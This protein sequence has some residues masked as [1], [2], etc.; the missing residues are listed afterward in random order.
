MAVA[1]VAILALAM[2]SDSTRVA[3]VSVKKVALATQTGV[4]KSKLD[5]EEGEASAEAVEEEFV[6]NLDKIHFPN[7]WASFQKTFG[8]H[9]TWAITILVLAALTWVYVRFIRP[10]SWFK[11]LLK[12]AKESSKLPID[13]AGTLGE[14]PSEIDENDITGSLVLVPGEAVFYNEEAA[15]KNVGTVHK[16]SVTNFR[17]IAQKAET[18]M[19]GTCQVS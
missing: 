14:V 8:A 18:T 10:Q 3:S 16:L 15:S 17:L 1:T 2:H 19:F 6:P 11:D 9:L 7:T 13:V 4:H 12:K 5:G